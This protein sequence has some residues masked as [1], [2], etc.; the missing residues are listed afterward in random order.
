[1]YPIFLKQFYNKKPSL[2]TG[3]LLDNNTD[4]LLDYTFF[5]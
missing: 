2:S 5:F 4:V 3:V 1:M